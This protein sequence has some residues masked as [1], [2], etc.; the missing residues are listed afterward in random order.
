MK[1]APG[2]LASVASAASHGLWAPD[3]PRYAEVA[4]EVF[5]E[6]GLLVMRLCGDLYPDKPPLLFWLAGLLGKLSNWDPFWMRLVSILATL[7]TAGLAL[8]R[9]YG[10]GCGADQ[11]LGYLFS[12]SVA[13]LRNIVP[14]SHC[15]SSISRYRS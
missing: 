4:R 14:D 2:R 10:G 12:E 1:S 6:P 15:N 11:P 9:K 3:E 7:G 13:P 8:R 5:V